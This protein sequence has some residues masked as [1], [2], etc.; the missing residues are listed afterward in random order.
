MAYDIR[1]RPAE[2]VAAG[3]ATAVTLVIHGALAPDHLEEAPY[4]GKAFILVAVVL[5]AA[6]SGLVLAPDR[7]L[8]WLLGAATCVGTAA[9]FVVSRTVGLP[10][11]HES[12]SSDNGLGLVSLVASVVVVGCAAGPLLRARRPAQTSVMPGTAGVAAGTGSTLR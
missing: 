10:D 2:R 1:P 11:I 5:A 4:L 9:G 3:I 6:L 8:P 12:W 7:A